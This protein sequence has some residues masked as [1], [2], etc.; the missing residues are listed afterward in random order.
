M[1]PVV[2]AV[3]AGLAAYIA[4]IALIP[5]RFL[6][7]SAHTRNMLE[8]LERESSQMGTGRQPAD[9]Q[10]ILREHMQESGVLTRVFFTLPGAKKI[11]PNLMKAGLDRNIGMFFGV[12]LLILMSLVFALK[13]AGIWGVLTA[14]ALTYLAAWWYTNRRIAKR[15]QTFLNLFPDAL[16][17]IVRSV[18][19]G[20]PLNAAVRMVAENMQ[21]PVSTEFKQVADEIAFGSTLID[22]LKRLSERVDEPDTHFFVV[23]L[24]V[25]QEV[26]GNLA[27]VLS[28]LANII[29]K[30]K[31]LRLKI[32]AMTSEGRAT[33]WVLGL[34]PLFEFLAIYI[35]SPSH[36]TPLFVT[37][38]GNLILASAIGIVLLGAF[39]VRQ[40]I[41]I[42][43]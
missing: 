12:L 15:N 30:R 10:S 43:V 6:F 31:H 11:Y 5:K 42:E 41:N 17:M 3:L 14:L 1:E 23:V 8:Q 27:E 2:V 33:A 37:H 19:S 32:K 26:G 36:L 28:N 39:I 9:P 13:G 4:V 38:L 25:Q 7:E 16:D 20:Y 29:R 34:L 35:V 18:R 22:A 40:M 21:A 24:A